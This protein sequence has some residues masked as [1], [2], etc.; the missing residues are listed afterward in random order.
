MKRLLLVGLV[1]ALAGCSGSD[2]I[3]EPGPSAALA[4]TTPTD[5]SPELGTAFWVH[6]GDPATISSERLTLGLLDVL[7]DSR[8]P[9]PMMCIAAG[10]VQVHLDAQHP[11]DA[12]GDLFLGTGDASSTIAPY[13]GYTVHLLQVL[14][15]PEVGRAPTPASDYCVQLRVDPN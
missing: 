3:T 8:C 11:P 6:A 2:E 1:V 4:C 14:P 12:A 9:H 5:P 7:E 15:Y 13:S 10:Q